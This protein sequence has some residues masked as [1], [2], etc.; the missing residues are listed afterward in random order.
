MPARSVFVTGASGYIGNAVCKAFVRAGWKTF[1]LIRNS[2]A[3]DDLSASEIIPVIG[4]IDDA[5]LPTALQG[6]HLRFDV[7]VSCTEQVPGYGAHFKKAISF[8]RNIAKK[9]NEAGKRP[10]VLWTSG[11][12]DY[13][14]TGTH[15]SPGLEPHT[16]TSPLNS[17]NLLRERTDNCPKIFD[18]ADLF[19]AVLLRPTSV[20]GLSSSYYGSLF[21][22][23]EAESLRGEKE[24]II[25]ALEENV[26][27]ALHVDDCA[28]AYVQLAEYSDRTAIASQVFNI[29]SSRYETTAEVCKALAIEYG[30]KHGVKFV[31][32][33][34]EGEHFPVGL[35]LV[36]SF[37]QWVGSEKIRRLTGWRNVRTLFS[38]DLGTYRRSYEATK[39][40]GK[41]N[42]IDVQN[43]I[44]TNFQR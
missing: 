36:L 24:L 6:V 29:S 13:G 21:D 38:E 14:M 15:G 23:A 31:P 44:S 5:N 9:S 3:A 17:P 11:C 34:E 16:E 20:Y 18:H 25:P 33:N 40:N 7:I 10:L 8:I 19:D 41:G 39:R 22:F 28:N 35:N 2:A 32:P 43:R 42:I 27:H 4:N 30:F 12:K 26:M 1:G 37:S